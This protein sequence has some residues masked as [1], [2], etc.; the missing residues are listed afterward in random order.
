MPFRIVDRRSSMDLM[1]EVEK[2]LL[3]MGDTPW[4]RKQYGHRAKWL[5]QRAQLQLAK[6]LEVFHS[7]DYIESAFVP[8]DETQIQEWFNDCNSRS[9]IPDNGARLDF[10]APIKINMFLVQD[11][12]M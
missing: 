8:Q 12:A 3:N 7:I 9:A 1:E 4:N 6:K 11:L 5:Y 2:V 10:D